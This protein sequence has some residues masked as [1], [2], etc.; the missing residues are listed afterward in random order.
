MMGR[1]PASVLHRVLLPYVDRTILKLSRHLSSRGPGALDRPA[2]HTMQGRGILPRKPPGWGAAATRNHGPRSLVFAWRERPKPARANEFAA[3]TTRCPPSWTGL[4]SCDLH[5]GA[6]PGLCRPRRVLLLSSAVAVS[7]S[8][9]GGRR[10]HLPRG[11]PC[12]LLPAH[13]V[14]VP[15]TSPHPACEMDGIAARERSQCGRRCI[16]F[17]SP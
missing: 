16:L 12:P 9:E 1:A 11:R 2:V 6:R 10:K 13:P 3:T 14:H 4:L 8:P 15:P 7:A 17:T 5:D